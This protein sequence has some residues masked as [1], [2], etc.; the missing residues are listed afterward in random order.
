MIADK[1]F[2]VAYLENALSVTVNKLVTFTTKILSKFS[3]I[4]HEQSLLNGEIQ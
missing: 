2:S 4:K 1:Q 3:K